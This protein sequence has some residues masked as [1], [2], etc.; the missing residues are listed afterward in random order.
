VS[1]LT[2]DRSSPGYVLT[3][4]EEEQL[5]E[6]TFAD[7]HLMQLHAYLIRRRAV[8][9]SH[10]LSTPDLLMYLSSLPLFKLRA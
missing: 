2:I 4:T 3:A 5:R 1:L 7:L 8:H 10:K 9:V 6:S